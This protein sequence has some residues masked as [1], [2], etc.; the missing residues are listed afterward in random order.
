MIFIN[1][2]ES[3]GQIISHG[4]IGVTGG[5]VATMFMIL[6]ILIVIALMFGIPLEFLS[7]LVL[8]FC[9]AVGAFYGSFIIPVII[10]LLFVSMLIAK[11]WLFR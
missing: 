4:T 2:T 8:P 7:V 10:I 11:N 1:A 6:L 5:I 9:I 3:I